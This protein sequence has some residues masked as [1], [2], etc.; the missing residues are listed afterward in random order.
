MI[1]ISGIHVLIFIFGVGLSGNE[2][3]LTMVAQYADALEQIILLLDDE[4]Q[5][6]QDVLLCL[7]NISAE[8]IGIHG[9][10]QFETRKLKFN[11]FGEQ[12]IITRLANILLDPNDKVNS[13]FSIF[14]PI[15]N[16]KK[17]VSH[18]LFTGR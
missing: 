3:G 15:F 13:I 4:P 1:L 14:F 6:K 11:K 9:L 17:K 18:I 8:D 2:D 7:V 12:S 5:I 10:M 16:Q